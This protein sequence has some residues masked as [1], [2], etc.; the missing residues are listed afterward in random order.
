MKRLCCVKPPRFQNL[1]ERRYAQT[2]HVLDCS[3]GGRGCELVRT[4]RARATCVA[5][6]GGFGQQFPEQ[7][8]VLLRNLGR[9]E[10]RPCRGLV[11]WR[12]VV[13]W[14]GQTASADGLAKRECHVCRGQ[15]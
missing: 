13:G 8:D 5:L 12:S 1:Q 6:T 10:E 7:R 3:G 9:E 14:E 11:K 15:K 4:D 2:S